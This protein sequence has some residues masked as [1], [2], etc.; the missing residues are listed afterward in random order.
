MKTIAYI[1]VSTVQQ[2]TEVQRQAIRAY[3]KQHKIRVTRYV[4]LTMSSRKSTKERKIDELLNQLDAGDT[5]I[6][7]ELSRLARSVGQIAIITKEL[8]ER[9]IR[10]IFIKENMDLAPNG[11]A[12]ISTKVQITMF[13]L[14][15]EIERDLISLRTKEGLQAA[16]AKGV[17]LGRKPGTQ[18]ASKFDAHR[19]YIVKA[20]EMKVPV[21]VICREL[22]ASRVGIDHYINSRNLRP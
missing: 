1:R 2:D 12:D 13:S 22:K 19:D 10:I 11:K 6:M 3:C 17:R 7:S 15:V 5:L 8:I 18:V 14:F 4:E 16:R 9:H 20:L 21:S